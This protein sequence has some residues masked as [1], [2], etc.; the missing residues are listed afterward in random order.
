MLENPEDSMDNNKD[1][2]NILFIIL[3]VFAFSEKINN[4][5]S[6]LENEDY[7]KIAHECLESEI[8]KTLNPD[9]VPS[10]DVIS[11]LLA[12]K[13]ICEN[14]ILSKNELTKNWQE[15]VFPVFEEYI[16]KYNRW[17][18]VMT[19]SLS[20]LVLELEEKS[21]ISEVTE[22]GFCD[23]K[24]AGYNNIIMKISSQIEELKKH[25]SITET[26]MKLHG[27]K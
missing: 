5:C 12:N 2:S 15:S 24:L 26:Y 11:G 14:L 19:L 25:K 23:G 1:I 21:K 20:C 6:L 16:N 17:P 9:F 13:N 10:V 3:S 8:F 4:P 22:S 18:K 7:M 27:K